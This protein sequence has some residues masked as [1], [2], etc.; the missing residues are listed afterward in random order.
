LKEDNL[1]FCILLSCAS[2]VLWVL[3]AERMAVP[4][5]GPVSSSRVD[6]RALSIDP[7]VAD[8][9]TLRHLPGIGPALARRLH[10]ES[11]VLQLDS[12]DQLERIRGIGPTRARMIRDAV[13]DFED[14]GSD[15]P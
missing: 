1:V 5:M 11:R 6:S 3:H 12:L 9:R 14:T 13:T 15:A 4:S 10:H 7:L 2:C 8:V